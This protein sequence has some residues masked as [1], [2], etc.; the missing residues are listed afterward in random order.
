MIKVYESL[1]TYEKRGNAGWIIL[2]R[3]EKLNC[4]N[5]EFA[6][7]LIQVAKALDID[8]EIRCIVISGKRNFSAGADV[9]ELETVV[10][11][12]DALDWVKYRCLL[13]ET[14]ASL[15]KPTI[16]AIRGYALGGGLELALATDIR[17]CSEQA[18]FGFPEAKIGLLP[19]G[20]GIRRL[21][22]LTGA[23]V[24]K[25][26]MYTG[27]RIDAQSAKAL[28]LINR[29]VADEDL[30]ATVSALVE[31]IVSSQEDAVCLIKNTVDNCQDLTLER[32]EIIEQ[33]AFAL[34]LSN[35]N[36]KNR[37]IEFTASHSRR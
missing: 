7:K 30:E 33:Q 19:G 9:E 4:I 16:A 27:R 14:I 3:E 17:I 22:K 23:A 24:A 8:P 21:I 11:S 34:L 5:S 32:A 10:S 35:P 13:Y 31:E 36:T 29:V 37:I 1:I 18:K 2:T 6:G 28:G 25:E 20:G 15:S 26:V 12:I